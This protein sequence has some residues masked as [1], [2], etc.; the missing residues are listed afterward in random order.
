MR[1]Y[2]FVGT[3]QPSRSVSGDYYDFIIRPD[4][5]IY[6]VIAD[7]SGK[8]VPAG[9][10]MAGLQIAFRIFAKSDL[11]GPPRPFE[12]RYRARLQLNGR[13]DIRF[14]EPS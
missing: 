7:V 12:N 4:G 2:T 14:R 5:R 11:I 1:G 13:T 3:N 6:F 9:L 10:M 8:G